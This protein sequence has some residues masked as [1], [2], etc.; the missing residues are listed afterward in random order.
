MDDKYGDFRDNKAFRQQMKAMELSISKKTL[1]L[2]A[3]R[4]QLRGGK[5]SLPVTCRSC[6]ENAQQ[7]SVRRQGIC[8]DPAG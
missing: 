6:G 8:E 7:N 4:L 2:H 1:F 3:G 5:Q